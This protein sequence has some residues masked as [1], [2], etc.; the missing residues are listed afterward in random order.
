MWVQEGGKE[1][2]ETRMLEKPKHVQNVGEE[3][4]RENTWSASI[5]EVWCIPFLLTA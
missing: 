4:K 1:D 5:L 3:E 2:G